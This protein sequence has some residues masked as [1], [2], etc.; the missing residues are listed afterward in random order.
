MTKR[1]RFIVEEESFPPQS[2]ARSIKRVW[3]KRAFC[4]RIAAAERALI[5]IMTDSGNRVRIR[6]ARS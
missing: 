5:N 1:P 2:A 6:E 4:T 3:I